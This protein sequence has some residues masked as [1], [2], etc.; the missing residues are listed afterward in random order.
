MRKYLILRSQ[1]NWVRDVLKQEGLD[2]GEFAWDETP[3]KHTREL[4]E[5]EFVSQLTHQPTAY[6]FTF[7]LRRETFYVS[8][9]PGL[10][11]PSVDDAS[12]LGGT[13]DWKWVKTRV[14]DWARAL[15]R[16]IEAPDLWAAVRSE[17]AIVQA[18]AAEE[19]VDFTEEEKK[20]LG[21]AIT[22][23]GAYAKTISGD[24][25]EAHRRIEQNIEYLRGA[26]ERL[27]KRDWLHTAIGVLFTIAMSLS[28]EQATDLF[29][30][31]GQQI[32]GAV[33]W[34]ISQVS[35]LLQ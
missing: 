26:V 32:T 19:N 16:E 17:K 31:A 27:P 4:A 5:E 29:R 1:A 28:S 24:E 25:E 13:S 6:C 15:K 30:F 14:R 3:A 11:I 10:D 2:P 8:F 23:I 12:N 34:T 18:A 9:S 33:Q 21:E 7:D 20:R 35:N 22:E